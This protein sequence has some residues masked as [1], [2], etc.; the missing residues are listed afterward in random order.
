M[1]ILD[2]IDMFMIDERRRGGM[3]AE[4]SNWMAAYE[5]LLAKRGD[6]QAGR[7]DWDTATYMYNTG[8]SPE[9]AVKNVQT[10]DP[11]KAKGAR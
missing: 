2:K 10:R 9:Q 6:H 8:I 7:V 11:Y 5:K 1:D 4:R 3:E